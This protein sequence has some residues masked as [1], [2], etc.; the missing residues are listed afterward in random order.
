MRAPPVAV[1]Q[2]KG[3]FCSTASS[4][5]AHEA[6]A[7]HGA[8]GAAHEFEF[9]TGDHHRLT[10]VTAP[11]MTTSASVSPVFVQRVVQAL[12]V[13]AAVLELERDRPAAL[14]GPIS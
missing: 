10:A 4:H 2:M 7:D 6:L 13:L 1:K 14:P 5:A 11:P 9:E 3:T 12:G 8:H